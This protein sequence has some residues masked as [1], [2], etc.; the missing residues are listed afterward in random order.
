M[1][2]GA[3]AT[4]D[5]TPEGTPAQPAQHKVPLPPS[6][7]AVARL[8][9][10]FRKFAWKITGREID[11]RLLTD[12][13]RARFVAADPRPPLMRTGWRRLDTRRRFYEGAGA[14]G[15]KFAGRA[16]PDWELVR[17]MNAGRRQTIRESAERNREAVRVERAR[18]RPF[19]K[20]T[21][22]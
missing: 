5:G 4:D 18:R 12:E 15:R 14:I 20:F 9:A 2:E 11:L 19:K 7:S 10:E 1:I 17:Q 6:R 16:A 13:E 8:L 3:G 22:G 21:P